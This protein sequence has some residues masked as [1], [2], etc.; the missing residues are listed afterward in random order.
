MVAFTYYWWLSGGAKGGVV[1]SGLE[2]RKKLP[3]DPG[4]S[5]ENGVTQGLEVLW[6]Q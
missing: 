5:G 2:S 6:T 3:R 1:W 4:V